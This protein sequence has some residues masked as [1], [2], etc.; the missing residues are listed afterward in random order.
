MNES[1]APDTKL[2]MP[3]LG[4][5]TW[6]RRGCN[7]MQSVEW[8]LEAGYRHVDT[9][10]GYDNEA[11]CG[12]AIDHSG[13]PRQDIYITTK[14]KPQNLSRSL[15]LDTLEESLFRLRIDYLDM[16]LIHWP[17]PQNEVPL[18]E[19]IEGLI[20]AQNRGITR[21][22]GLSNFT[23][24]LLNQVEDI[25]GKGVFGNLQVELHVF[26]GNSKIVEYCKAR[27]IKITAFSPLALGRVSEN[28]ILASIAQ[29]YDAT[30]S[31]VALAFL[32]QSGFNAIP[33]SSNQK[34]IAENF[35]AQHV[36]LSPADL[37]SIRS[38]NS[39]LRLLSPGHAPVWD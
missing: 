21:N 9:A 12:L 36:T 20:E 23:I 6:M 35:A 8:A 26:M 13:I 16:T 1:H 33:T 37:S 7:G 10:Q 24:P 27:N 5:G 22:I 30:A 14:V 39:N 32:L 34:R 2:T 19:Y 25:A 17:S 28:D 15:L 3:Q 29:R 18:A 11:M 4:Y 31:Q 38:L